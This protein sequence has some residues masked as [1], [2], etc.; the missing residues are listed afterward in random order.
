MSHNPYRKRG[1]G[2]NRGGGRGRGR[3]RGGRGGGPPQGLSGK[4]IGMYYKRKGLA[5]KEEQEK[6]EV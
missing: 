2:P 6:N 3:E 4:D 1:G 5:K